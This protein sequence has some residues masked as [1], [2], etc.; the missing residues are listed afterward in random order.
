MPFPNHQP[1]TRYVRYKQMQNTAVAAADAFV[2]MDGHLELIMQVCG[3]S[4]PT[5]MGTI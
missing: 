3:G 4:G 2:A 5:Q 1:I